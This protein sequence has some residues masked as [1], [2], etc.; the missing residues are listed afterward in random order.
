MPTA[1]QF[2]SGYANSFTVWQWICQQLYCLA[3][4]MPTALLFGSGYANS[5]TV[6]QWICQQLYL[7]FMKIRLKIMRLRKIIIEMLYTHVAL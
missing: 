2:G 3:V 1:L 6:W 4:D 5:F 7:V